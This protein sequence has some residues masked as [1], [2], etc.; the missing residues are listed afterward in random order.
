MKLYFPSVLS[1]STVI[2]NLVASSRQNK[3]TFSGTVS[4]NGTGEK[5]VG[6]ATDSPALSTTLTLS[7]AAQNAI[8]SQAKQLNDM[9]NALDKL[10]AMP[11]ANVSAKRAAAERAAMLKKLLDMLKQMMIGATPAEAKAM[12]SQLKDIAKELASMGETLSG[13]N[14]TPAAPT[15]AGIVATGISG[16]DNNSTS[17]VSA[18]GA[19]INQSAVTAD[20]SSVSTVGTDIATTMTATVP[21]SPSP[22]SKGTEVKEG[23]EASS[24]AGVSAATK[25]TTAIQSGN[26]Q[27]ANAAY[28]AQDTGKIQGVQNA[29][30]K[31]EVEKEA[32]D[33]LKSALEDARKALRAAIAMLKS[34]LGGS[35]KDVK[36][37][38]QF[39][40][41][42][43]HSLTQAENQ[44]A[45]MNS[46][47][48]NIVTGGGQ[49]DVSSST[50]SVESVGG[51]DTSISVAS[52]GGAVGSSISVSA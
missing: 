12:A 5:T 50:A 3:T 52:G 44:D 48:D 9:Q 6:A 21:D 31:N 38:E 25:L 37:T 24:D 32:N 14:S 15:N 22:A 18:Q 40:A 4:I 27:K 47:M 34:K 16:S 13:G 23:K 20:I 26:A 8:Q 42:L 51:V 28:I 11:S 41:K 43:D 49:A 45:S 1:R 46:Q 7:R 17:N 10:R 30:S 19:A 35:N 33:A 29:V 39:L 2:S 36:D